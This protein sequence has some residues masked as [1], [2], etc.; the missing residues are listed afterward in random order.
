LK[1]HFDKVFAVEV[2]EFET[3]KPEGKPTKKKSKA[4]SKA[5]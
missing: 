4:K 2:K 5:E 3:E 1:D